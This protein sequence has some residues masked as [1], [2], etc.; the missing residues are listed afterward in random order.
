M[1]GFSEHKAQ[2]NLNFVLL[3]VHQL[4]HARL[5]AIKCTFRTITQL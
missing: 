5:P 4:C 2:K 3:E 1:T